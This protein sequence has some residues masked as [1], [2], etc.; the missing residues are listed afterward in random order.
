LFPDDRIQIVCPTGAAADATFTIFMVI[1]V[2]N[3]MVI[4]VNNVAFI[5]R[6]RHRLLKQLALYMGILLF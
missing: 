5:V 3:V 4:S 6:N 1:S 2:N